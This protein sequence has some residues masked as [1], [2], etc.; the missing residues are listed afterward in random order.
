[1]HSGLRGETSQLTLRVDIS[2]RDD[3]KLLY[4]YEK[5]QYGMVSFNR[6]VVIKLSEALDKKKDI[7]ELVKG[8]LA[9]LE[10]RRNVV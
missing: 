2:M 1:M 8:R 5:K 6:W 3:L 7:L 9:E 4:A 10:Q